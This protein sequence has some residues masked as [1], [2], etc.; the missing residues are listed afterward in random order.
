[1]AHRTVAMP[2]TVL[3]IWERGGEAD[4]VA[5]HWADLARYL[6]AAAREGDALLLW[7]S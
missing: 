4:W 3:L 1:M 7:I 5:A 6:R 2:P